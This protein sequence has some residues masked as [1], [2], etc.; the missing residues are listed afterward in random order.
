[1]LVGD[2]D[3]LAGSS[4]LRAQLAD[5]VGVLR[6]WSYRWSADSVATT[7]AVLWGDELW[8]HVEHE[9]GARRASVYDRMADPARSGQRL[10]TLASVCD[11]LTH[12]FGG[13]RVPWGDVNRYQRLNGDIVQAFTDAAPSLPVPFTSARWGSLASFGARRYE[14]T[15]KYYGTS[16][17]SFV[18]IVEFGEKV[19]ARA[20][21]I[22]GE[23]GDPGS[24]HFRDQATRYA[25][26]ALRKVYFYPAEL[27]G[28]VERDYHPR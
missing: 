4:P 2:Y 18:A 27:E 20:V 9:A 12:D 3:A 14:G 26:G 17:N 8:G 6:A 1:V 24:P 7:L 23:S 16:G 21:S 25:K 28:H 13:W 10:S 19:S 11:R 22:G 15:A 5:P